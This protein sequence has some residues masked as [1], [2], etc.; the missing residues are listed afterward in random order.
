VGSL[1]DVLYLSN[2]DV[3]SVL[4]MTTCLDALRDGYRDLARGDAAYIPRIDLWAPTGGQD[5]YYC[6]GSMT[7]ASRSAGVVAVRIKS[8]VITWSDGGKTTEKY[9]VQPGTYSG[10]VLLYSI[11]NG[12]PLA[13]MNDGYVQHMRVGGCA[14][15][16]V[17]A[18]ARQDADVLGLVGSGGM[19]RT[20]LEA[21]HLVRSLRQVKVF[22]PT[23]GHRE[24]FAD[25][26]GERL[27]LSIQAVDT[28]EEAVRDSAIVA[29][30]TD[31][32]APTFRP[33]WVAPGAH[34]TCVTRRELD[35][36]IVDRA[37]VVVQLGVHTIPPG[38][39]VPGMQWPMS[40][41]A[42]YV[43]G[44]PEERARLPWKAPADDGQYSTLAAVRA[45]GAP[46]RT[47]SPPSAASARR[48]PPSGSSRT[49][50]TEA[51]WVARNG[52]VHPPDTDVQFC[53]V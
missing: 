23:R 10:I 15:L 32:M 1:P 39:P 27:G 53:T 3:Q 2:A 19:A 49:S 46:G 28:A 8:D 51:G 52:R 22:S 50:A 18:L 41:V 36:T 35:K 31:A 37:D 29:T 45:G 34:V 7:G 24:Q 16:G 12:E 47:S 9:C 40:A 30:A 48:C 14:G 6:F 25:E 26:M 13:L 42:G 5:D 38:T 4:D 33:E 44:Q 21:I 11:R 20:Y 17:D 43:A